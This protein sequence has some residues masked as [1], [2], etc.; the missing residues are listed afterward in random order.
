MLIMC[1]TEGRREEG[2]GEGEGE[3]EQGRIRIVYVMPHR[4]LSRRCHTLRAA[5]TPQKWR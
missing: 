2:E 3:E 5:S 1:I 4:L